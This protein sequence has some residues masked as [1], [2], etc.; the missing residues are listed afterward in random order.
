M[1]MTILSRYLT[2]QFYRVFIMTFICL[3]G[4]SV[5]GDLVG[6]FSEL[7]DYKKSHA[8]L[9]V[10]LSN[11]YLARVP[12]FFEIVGRIV[13]LL[14]GVFVL[15]GMQRHNE[16]TAVMAAGGSRWQVARPL[17]I[18]AFLIAAGGIAN[19]EWGIPHFRDIL[20]RDAN[21]IVRGK[22]RPMLPRYD[23]KTNVLFGGTSLV[24]REQKIVL[25]NVRLPRAWGGLGQGIRGETATFVPATAEHPAGY[26]IEK[27]QSPELLKETPSLVLQGILLALG[28]AD[29]AWLEKDQCLIVSSLPVE[30]FMRSKRWE[31]YSSTGQLLEGIRTG[32]IDFTPDVRVLVHLRFVQPFLDVCLFFLGLPFSFGTN[33][34]AVFSSAFKTILIAVLFSGVSIVGKAFGSQEILPAAVAAWLPLLVF[35]PIAAAFSTRFTQ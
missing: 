30:A 35:A 14:A 21:D 34:R 18:A 22:P 11:Y 10:L 29:N 4:M 31:Q 32:S 23:N 19:R 33:R 3:F 12:W 24:P 1:A 28:P 27:V 7:V 16:L 26:L 20:C 17:C 6:H 13:C 9:G 25:P 8:D 15:S 2:W 5:I